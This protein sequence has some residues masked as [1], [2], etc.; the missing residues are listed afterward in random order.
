MTTMNRQ[1]LL[2]SRPSGIPQA[3]VYAGIQDTV[4]GWIQDVCRD[5]GPGTQLRRAR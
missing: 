5:P 1:V 4:A 3:D 2:Q